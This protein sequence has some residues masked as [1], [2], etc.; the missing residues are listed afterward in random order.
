MVTK[1]LIPII[2]P[3]SLLYHSQ[4]LLSWSNLNWYNSHFSK[5]PTGN[6]RKIK[7]MVNYIWPQKEWEN[8]SENSGTKYSSFNKMHKD[9]CCGNHNGKE[10]EIYFHNAAQIQNQWAEGKSANA[11]YL[12]INSV[13]YCWWFIL[14]T[15]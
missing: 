12:V 14:E 13:F 8:I 11:V 3:Y 10:S 7:N 4:C 9:W 1:D 15:S 6:N 2:N 5:G